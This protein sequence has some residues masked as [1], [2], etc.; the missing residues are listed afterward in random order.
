MIH[1][2]SEGELFRGSLLADGQVVDV[3]VK[4]LASEL[5]RA[6]WSERWQAQAEL[7]ATVH[8]D[9]PIDVVRIIDVFEGASPHRR[10]QAAPH[11]RELYLLT[12]WIDGQRL[13]D[14]CWDA[15]VGPIERVAMIDSL[16]R[17]VDALHQLGV[18]HRDLAPGNVMVSEGRP[19]L[20]D[21]GLAVRCRAG[22][23]VHEA[24]VVGTDGY[25]SPDASAGRWSHEADHYALDR[26]TD[27]ALPPTA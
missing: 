13:D 15:A 9:G 8:A 2:G 25:R 16:R 23:W 21:F 3:A 1:Q 5:D 20:I 4:R 27:L 14:W 6:E 18:I 19:V 12:E 26:L 11:G 7:L 17:T 22:E 24:D 10:R